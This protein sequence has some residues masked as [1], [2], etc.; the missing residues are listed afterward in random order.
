MRRMKPSWHSSLISCS[1]KLDEV[2][3]KK[4]EGGIEEQKWKKSISLQ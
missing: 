4:L 3:G 1:L 2:H